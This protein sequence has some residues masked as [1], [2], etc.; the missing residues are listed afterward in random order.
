MI[1]VKNLTKYYGSVRAIADVSFNVQTG[2]ILGL[3]GPNGAGKTTTMRI[4]TCLLS[5]TR[6][7]ARV[8]GFDISKEPLQVRRRIGYLPENAPLYLDMTVSAY[9]KFVAEVKAIDPAQRRK[10]IAEVTE[11]CGLASV[12]SRILRHLSKGYRQRACLAQALLN[13]PQV[14]ILDEPTLGLDPR[15]VTEMRGLIK[16]LAG[17]STVILSTHILSEADMTCHR[18]VIINQGRV[19]AEGAP[20][21]LAQNLEK[22]TEIFLEIQGPS[23]EVVREL[24]E[25]PGVRRVNLK[26]SLAENVHFYAVESEKNMD[27]RKEISCRIVHKEW[28]LLQM[29]PVSMGLEDIFLKLITQQKTER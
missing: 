18:V 3:L 20:R 21:N 7:E 15:Q 6:G 17:R 4:L 14:L 2:E 9:L 8:A 19:V 24:A 28:G 5:P 26:N 13:E 11:N 27:I 25:I 29:R 1:E 12:S 22:S 23:S 16:N 10:R